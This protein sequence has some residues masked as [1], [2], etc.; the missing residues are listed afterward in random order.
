MAH[1]VV[2][3][4]YATTMN[5]TELLIYLEPQLRYLASHANS[6]KTD[7]S[8]LYEHLLSIYTEYWIVII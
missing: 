5:Q 4:A 8:C 7:K 3:T 6:Y 2:G 1:F